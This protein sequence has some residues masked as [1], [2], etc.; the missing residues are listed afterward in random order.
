M[1]DAG[2]VD[3][4]TVGTYAVTYNVSDSAGNAA[5][6]AVR[7][8]NVIPSSGTGEVITIPSG[9]HTGFTATP[10]DN[11]TYQCEPG[12]I[13]DGQG[14]TTYAFFGSGD[15]VSIIGCEIRNYNN[16]PQQ[17]AIHGHS[18]AHDWLVRNND[19]HDNW[20]KHIRARWKD[21]HPELVM[22][23]AEEAAG[24]D[25]RDPRCIWTLADFGRKEI[26]DLMVRGI[27]EV[28]DG[29]RQ[30]KEGSS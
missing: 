4:M 20:M 8:V 15:N 14:S 18:G 27:E 1:V 10:E 21:E 29:L 30:R 11:V 5:V 7:T 3:I 2:E 9:L 23:T 28:L 16:P 17:G 26:R 25:M 12:A 13:L 6:E 19:I 24:H 22:G